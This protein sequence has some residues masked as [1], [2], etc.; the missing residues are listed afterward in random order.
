VLLVSAAEL[1]GEVEEVVGN[2]IEI[3]LSFDIPGL[4]RAVLE[5]LL[6]SRSK[7]SA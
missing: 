6:D 2:H 4:G 3:V 1:G 5:R 7:E